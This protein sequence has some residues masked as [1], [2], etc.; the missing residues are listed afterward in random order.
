MPWIYATKEL[1]EE[2]RL[3]E[4]AHPGAVILLQ[5]GPMAHAFGQSARRVCKVRGWKATKHIWF[6]AS[7]MEMTTKLLMQSGWSV[8]EAS[9]GSLSPT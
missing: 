8:V 1:E 3:I 2:A 4:R 5:N 6:D 7:T 9:I